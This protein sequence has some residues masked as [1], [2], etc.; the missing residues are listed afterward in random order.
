[1]GASLSLPWARLGSPAGL[2]LLEERGYKIAA[3]VLDPGASELRSWEAPARVALVLGNEAFG[4]SGPWLGSCADRLTLRMPGGTDSLNV[5]TA[6]AIFLYELAA[7]GRAGD[8]AR[9]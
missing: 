1:M 9:L 5:S 6:A 3:C 8:P 7:R 4:L 2:A